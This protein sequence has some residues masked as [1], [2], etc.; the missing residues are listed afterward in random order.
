MRALNIAD[1]TYCIQYRC[2]CCMYGFN[3]KRN[4]NH[5]TNRSLEPA[6]ICCTSLVTR[7]LHQK[8]IKAKKTK[9][10]FDEHVI[11]N[12]KLRTN[13][14]NCVNKEQSSREGIHEMAGYLQSGQA[15]CLDSSNSLRAKVTAVVQSQF[16]VI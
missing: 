6:F 13:H 16:V 7:H 1:G 10:F 8:L 15:S 5:H 11:N 2:Y 12:E 4:K 9:T 14:R 3:L